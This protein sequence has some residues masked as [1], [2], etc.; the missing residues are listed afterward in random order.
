MTHHMCL[1]PNQSIINLSSYRKPEV[2]VFRKEFFVKPQQLTIFGA[3]FFFVKSHCVKISQ[4]YNILAK[5]NESTYF[6][7]KSQWEKQICHSRFRSQRE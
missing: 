5:T 2:S 1:L 3:K 7:V 4:Y 6:L